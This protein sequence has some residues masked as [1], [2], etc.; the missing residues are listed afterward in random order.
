MIAVNEC[1]VSNDNMKI[2][3]D[4]ETDL[5]YKITSAKLWSDDTFKVFAKAK[6]IN[7]TSDSNQEILTVTAASM[8][9]KKFDGLYF[10][11]FETDA[12]NEECSTCPNPVTA[13]V[14]N[15]VSYYKCGMEMILK[16][17]RSGLD[18]FNN[19]SGEA[20]NVMTVHLLVDAVNE[21]IKLNRFV[22]AINLLANLKKVCRSC[23]GSESTTGLVDCTDC[24]TTSIY[25]N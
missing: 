16:S 23:S 8:G 21:A 5:G 15:L 25:Y 17:S 19:D 4:V 10:I 9:V 13:V 2:Y 1:R 20:N 6:I 7:I 11:E 22:D 3:I 18:I 14:S 12:P 24:G